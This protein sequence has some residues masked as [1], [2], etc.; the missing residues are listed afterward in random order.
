LRRRKIFKITEKETK[1]YSCLYK[2]QQ[3]ADAKVAREE[4]KG[5]RDA[6]KKAKAERLAAN[7]QKALKLS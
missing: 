4:A 3:Q 5:L 6:E 1:S 2:K 7:T